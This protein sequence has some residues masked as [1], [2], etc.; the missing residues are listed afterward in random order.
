MI[1]KEFKIIK[2]LRMMKET[3]KDLSTR[4]THR[5]EFEYI[6]LCLGELMRFLFEDL[7]KKFAGNKKFNK[8]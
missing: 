5:E 4:T 3:E 2:K 7:R 6:G 1:A 8:G